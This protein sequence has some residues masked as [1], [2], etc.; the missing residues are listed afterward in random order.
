MLYL[1]ISENEHCHEHNASHD[2]AEEENSVDCHERWPLSL[3]VH[4]HAPSLVH[5]ER[6]PLA[7]QVSSRQGNVKSSANEYGK[8]PNDSD[9]M[10]QD[11]VPTLF[12]RV[13]KFDHAQKD[14]VR[15]IPRGDHNQVELRLL[16]LHEALLAREDVLV[17]VV[18]DAE[19]SV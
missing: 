6:G 4:E 13:T 9:D 5:R 12:E 1:V 16:W 8:G 3:L 14:V 11:E 2:V 15:D 19:A 7:H 18:A 10:V 17:R